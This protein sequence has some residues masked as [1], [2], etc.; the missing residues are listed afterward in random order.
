MR[1][2]F[3]ATLLILALS[4]PAIA[5]AWLR[6]EGGGFASSSATVNRDKEVSGSVYLEYGLTSTRTLGADIS[7]GFDRTG[8]QEG[9]A[10]IF[11]RMPLGPTDQT[12]KYAMH[13]GLGARI[14]NGDIQPAAE[15]GLSWGRSIKLGERWGWLNVDGSYNLT[16]SPLANRIKIDATAG[17]ALTDRTKLMIQ[18]F[19]TFQDGDT[20]TKLAPSLLV[21]VG[22]KRTTLQV[23]AELPL[24]GGGTTAIRLALWREW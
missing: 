20:F 21:S 4:P 9:S 23:G 19:N 10:I 18:M 16:Q 24:S 8:V 6:D 15:A 3:L 14:L 22:K 13:V 7:Y 12:H 17:L 2:T 1:Q 5:G 11:L